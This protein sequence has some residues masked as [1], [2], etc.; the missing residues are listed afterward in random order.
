MQQKK[1]NFNSP[2]PKAIIAF[3]DGCNN[4]YPDWTLDFLHQIKQN[5][6]NTKI[7]CVALGLSDDPYET[8]A[9]IK[10]RI[11]AQLTGGKAFD[12]YSSSA[13]DSVY[14]ELSSELVNEQYCDIVFK[15]KIKELYSLRLVDLFINCDAEPNTTYCTEIPFVDIFKNWNKQ[16]PACGNC[17][18]VRYCTASDENDY[19]HLRNTL[20]SMGYK[21]RERK[22][23]MILDL[24]SVNTF[25]NET[26]AKMF[27][28]EF[29]VKCS[30][31]PGE[32]EEEKINTCVINDLEESKLPVYDPSSDLIQKL[33]YLRKW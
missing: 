5:T 13:L 17:L 14:K 6:P 12:V 9:R 21:I 20:V 23:P 25:E 31:H 33:L 7:Y 28:E 24:V 15:A 32:I 11:L 29:K 2:R 8:D 22:N 1:I 10:M 19:K 30:I 27:L 18:R 16:R 26:E 4:I 3:S